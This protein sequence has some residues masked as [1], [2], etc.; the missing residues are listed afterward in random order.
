MFVK[1]YL[2]SPNYL[3]YYKNNTTKV[4]KRGDVRMNLSEIIEGGDIDAQL[5]KSIEK[6]ISK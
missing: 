6:I 1:F 2:N 3:K 5:K 4:S